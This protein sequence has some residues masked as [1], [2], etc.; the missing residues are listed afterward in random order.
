MLSNASTLY[1]AAT[2]NILPTPHAHQHVT[3]ATSLPPL[4]WLYLKTCMNNTLQSLPYK[5]EYFQKS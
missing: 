4:P 5:H 3:H 2:R 1:N